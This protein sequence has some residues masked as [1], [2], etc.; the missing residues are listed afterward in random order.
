MPEISKKSIIILQC[1]YSWHRS[2]KGTVFC[3]LY[4]LLIVLVLLKTGLYLIQ[5]QPTETLIAVSRQTNPTLMVLYMASLVMMASLQ[6]LAIKIPLKTH[7][8]RLKFAITLL[9]SAATNESIL[10]WHVNQLIVD[11]SFLNTSINIIVLILIIPLIQK[12]PTN[13][14]FLPFH[15]VSFN[16]QSKI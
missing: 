5:D 14:W 6:I 7:V 15:G 9:I 13:P 8:N 12:S 11:W 2:W 1:E 3:I 4:F 16:P 10:I